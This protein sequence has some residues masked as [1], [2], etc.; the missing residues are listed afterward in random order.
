[1]RTCKECGFEL[2]PE[3]ERSGRVLCAQCLFDDEELWRRWRK[4]PPSCRQCGQVI[5]AGRYCY[6]CGKRKGLW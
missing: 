4:K 5:E 3:E 1:M 2:T 6:W